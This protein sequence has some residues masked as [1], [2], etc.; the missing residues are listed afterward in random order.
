MVRGAD[1]IHCGGDGFM[2]FFLFDVPRGAQMGVGRYARLNG[3]SKRQSVK[4]ISNGGI[5]RENG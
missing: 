1:K 2:R 3:L 5:E 4:D